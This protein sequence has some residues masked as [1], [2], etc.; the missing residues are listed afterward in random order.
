MKV[1]D[2]TPKVRVHYIGLLNIYFIVRAVYG[3]EAD[4]RLEG[5]MV[6]LTNGKTKKKTALEKGN[7]GNFCR[8]YN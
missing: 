2:I 7:F 4:E 5:A 1:T 6:I 8:F 3:Q